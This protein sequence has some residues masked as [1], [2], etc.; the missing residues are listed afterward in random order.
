ML[1]HTLTALRSPVRPHNVNL[2]R[3][4]HPLYNQHSVLKVYQHDFTELKTYCFHITSYIRP[5]CLKHRTS[6]HGPQ[7]YNNSAFQ[8]IVQIFAV[9]KFSKIL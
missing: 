3:L 5:K 2:L 6:L 7:I 8:I 1:V 9:F 4:V